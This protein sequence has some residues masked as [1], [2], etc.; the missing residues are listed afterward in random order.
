MTPRAPRRA[1]LRYVTEVKGHKHMAGIAAGWK[2]MM[3]AH[4]CAC[5]L[6]RTWW[7]QARRGFQEILAIKGR[8]ALSLTVGDLCGRAHSQT[9]D[10]KAP[11]H[12]IQSLFYSN[13]VQCNIASST[14]MAY[15]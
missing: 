3:C 11:R 9:C 14:S 7:G 6:S 15:A 1:P 10:A 2:H 13:P 4:A 5:L 8:V 12:C